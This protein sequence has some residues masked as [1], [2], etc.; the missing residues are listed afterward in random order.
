MT[1]K[2]SI[3]LKTVLSMD[4]GMMIILYLLA[5]G[6]L[7]VSGPVGLGHNRKEHGLSALPPAILGQ[8]ALSSFSEFE[9]SQRCGFAE[10]EPGFK[11]L[12]HH[13][14]SFASF[15]T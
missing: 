13:L 12:R 10:Y 8:A 14:L 2:N 7:M 1:Q 6:L 15:V 3:V 9:L 11:Y 5:N 4:S